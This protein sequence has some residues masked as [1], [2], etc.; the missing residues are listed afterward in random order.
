M[1]VEQF[2]HF[3]NF[4]YNLRYLQHGRIFLK[5]LINVSHILRTT[6][7]KARLF[8]KISLFMACFT[9]RRRTFF[10]HDPL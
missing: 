10:R 5:D 1:L 4:L 3:L 9:A 6:G 8:Y 2:E 7:E